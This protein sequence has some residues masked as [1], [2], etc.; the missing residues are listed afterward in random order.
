MPEGLWRRWIWKAHR[1]LSNAFETGSHP[2]FIGKE[3]QHLS[4]HILRCDRSFTGAKN[5]RSRIFWFDAELPGEKCDKH[6]HTAMMVVVDF[7]WVNLSL[8]EGMLFPKAPSQKCQL[9]VMPHLDRA[10][11]LYQLPIRYLFPSY[12]ESLFHSLIACL[13]F[14]G[15]LNHHNWRTNVMLHWLSIQNVGV[16]TIQEASRRCFFDS[17]WST[18]AQDSGQL[19]WKFIGPLRGL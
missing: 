8:A 5:A 3:L 17:P 2:F 6:G 12:I 11:A 9:T 13:A 7:Q 19:A 18:E 4:R 15:H 1:S 16:W 10:E 14:L